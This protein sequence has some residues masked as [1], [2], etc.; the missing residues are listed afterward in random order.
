LK[1]ELAKDG[2]IV[3][4]ATGK[5]I[6]HVYRGPWTLKEYKAHIERLIAAFGDDS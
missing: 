6:C 1:V 5:P 2:A 3:E 4:S